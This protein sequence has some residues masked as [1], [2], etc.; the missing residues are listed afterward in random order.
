MD[1]RSIFEN[2]FGIQKIKYRGNQG[3]GLCPFHDNRNPSLGWCIDNGLWTC[4][5]GCGSG[6]TYQFAERLNMPNKHDYIDDADTYTQ[7][8]HLLLYIR[9]L[10]LLNRKIS[11]YL[12]S[13][14]ESK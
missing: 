1:Y 13:M 7:R 8:T 14:K 10:T 3:M 9:L 12:R 6:N 4:H 2:D 11:L 5:A